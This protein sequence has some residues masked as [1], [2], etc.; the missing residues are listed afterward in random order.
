MPTTR[1]WHHERWDST[2][3]PDQLAGEAIPLP[4]RIMALADVYDALISSRIYKPA[5][6]HT[7][8]VAIIRTGRGTHFDPGLVDVFDGLHERFEEIAM[9]FGDSNRTIK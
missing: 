1:R 6:L 8:A 4:A 9:R 3:Y 7:E 5:L 2:G